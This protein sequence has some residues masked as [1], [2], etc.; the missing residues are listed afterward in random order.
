M[1]QQQSCMNQ[2][3][4]QSVVNQAPDG[5]DENSPELPR[6]DNPLLAKEPIITQVHRRHKEARLPKRR[7]LMVA[8]LQVRQQQG[9]SI[10]Y[11]LNSLPYGSIIQV[12]S[13]THLFVAQPV[14]R[15]QLSIYQNHLGNVQI[16]TVLS[17]QGIV[18]PHLAN[19][20]ILVTVNGKAIKTVDQA[21]ELLSKPEKLLLV[22]AEA[23]LDKK[24]RQQRKGTTR[25][26]D[27][28]LTKQ[29]IRK[30]NRS[31]L[32]SNNESEDR[33]ERRSRRRR[34][35]RRTHQRRGSGSSSSSSSS[36]RRHERRGSGSS[37]GSSSSCRSSSSRNAK[38]TTPLRNQD[39]LIPTQAIRRNSSSS[40]SM[41]SENRHLTDEIFVAKAPPASNPMDGSHN[42]DPTADSSMESLK[43]KDDLLN[44]T[45]DTATMISYDGD[46][47]FVLNSPK[48]ISPSSSVA[49]PMSPTKTT[50]TTAAAVVTPLASLENV[51]KIATYDDEQEGGHPLVF[52]T[53]SSEDSHDYKAR[54]AVLKTTGQKDVVRNKQVLNKLET[55]LDETM[56]ELA[57]VMIE[58]EDIQAGGDVVGD[59]KEG[60]KEGKTR[61]AEELEALEKE[62]RLR[63]FDILEARQRE[64]AKQDPTLPTIAEKA[65]LETPPSTPAVATSK[66][67]SILKTT[68][69]KPAVAIKEETEAKSPEQ[70][71]QDLEQQLFAMQ[72][73]NKALKQ[74]LMEKDSQLGKIQD[75]KQQRKVSSTRIQ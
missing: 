70:K 51:S 25:V 22:I 9:E 4:V 65:N 59:I 43:K 75:Q 34:R 28:V 31:L 66:E 57:F 39:K 19:G 61:T 23:P 49:S 8:G 3:A 32:S 48:L 63:I 45:M 74:E 33:Q 73:A 46:D 52:Q 55:Y 7:E 35:R 56:M 13:N 54:A 20:Q 16:A 21:V 38:A 15:L 30:S 26:V 71:M 69:S 18:P 12:E 62:L 29:D 53:S 11:L 67:E 60:A 40:S 47:S 58:I 5:T 37:H 2:D 14:R 17:Q 24:D 6:L 64:L 41:S 44:S 36:K 10:A 50:T 72:T 1:G 27:I 68:P 42:T